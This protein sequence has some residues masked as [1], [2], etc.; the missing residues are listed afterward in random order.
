MTSD[1]DPD[2]VLALSYVAAA[3]RSAIAALWRVDLAMG[4]VLAGGR[5]PMISQIKLAWWRESLERLDTSK[6]PAEPLLQEVETL[7]IPFGITGG[8]LAEME[9]GWSVLVEADQLEAEALRTYAQARGGL[10]FAYSARILG[11][12]GDDMV[13]AAGQAWALVDLARH[14]AE[15]DESDAALAAVRALPPLQRMPSRLRP[16]TMLA[17]LALRDAEPDRVKWEPQGSPGRML[18][19]LRHRMTGR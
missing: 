13:L 19:M 1:F 16:L 18:R 3:R 15:A 7:V 10:L 14:S 12:P 6:A 2:R 5:E 8:E 9:R 4:Q 11:H 17:A